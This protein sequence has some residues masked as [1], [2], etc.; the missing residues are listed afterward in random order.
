MEKKTR[1]SILVAA[2]GGTFS[3]IDSYAEEI[4]EA[5]ASAGHDVVLVAIGRR[6]ASELES[7]VSG[8]GVRVLATREPS[9]SPWSRLTRKLPTAALSELRRLMVDALS[10]TESRFDVAHVNHAALSPAA[11]LFAARVVAAGWF[12]PH[13][14]TGRLAETWRHTGRRFPKSAALAVK[15]LAHYVNDNVGYGSCDIVSAPTER[16]AAQLRSTG[17]DAVACPPPMRPAGGHIAHSSQRSPGG[18]RL[19][20]CCGDLTHPRKNVAAAIEAAG[21]L[22]AMGPAVELILIGRNARGLDA[23]IER[24]PKTVTVRRD[25]P[26]ARHDVQSRLAGSDVLVLPS[27]YEEWGYVATEALM[28]GTPVAAFPVYPFEEILLPPL[29]ICASGMTPRALARAIAAAIE[30]CGDRRLVRAAA[31]ERYG[32]EAARR[33]LDRLWY[34][35][36]QPG[37]NLVAAGH[38][39]LE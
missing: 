35:A 28:A 29:G 8:R 37:R 30:T 18:A 36:A 26:L 25:G 38:A 17:V 4:A 39:V 13:H 33:R 9:T 16:L 20:V 11:K 12:Y 5:A 27:L 23:A 32:T 22:A 34:G 10:E 1:L 15:G 21:H 6:A 19:A 24:L 14:A 2:H 31:A 3:G 7:R